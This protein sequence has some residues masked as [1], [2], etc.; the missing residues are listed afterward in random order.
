MASEVVPT[1]A[2]CVEIL[3]TPGSMFEMATIDVRGVPTRVWARA[4]PT[5]RALVQLARGHGDAIAL[6][7]EDERLSYEQTFQRVAALAE[8]LV[9]AC[10]VRKG[11]RVALAMRNYPEWPITFFAAVSAGAIVVPLNAWWTGAELQYGLADSGA[12]VLV[13]DEERARRV[14]EHLGDTDVAHLL[15]AR[16]VQRPAADGRDLAPVLATAHPERPLP[17]VEIEPDDDAT[18]FYTSGT[19]G[20]PK[21]ALGTHR[22]FTGNMVALAYGNARA[23]LRRRRP[24]DDTEPAAPAGQS[25]SLLTVPLFHATGSHSVLQGAFTTGSK[26]V[27]MYKWD[28]ERALELIE[29]ERVTAFGGVPSMV[30]QLLESPSLDTRDLS[31]LRSVSYGGAPAPP[32]LVRRIAQRFGGKPASN[33][34]GLTETSSVSTLNSGDDYLAK[35]DSV[36]APVAVTDVKVV[37]PDGDEVPVGD[38]GELWIKGPNVVRGYWRK[39]EATA[40]AFLPGGWFRSGDIARLDDEGFVYIVDRAKDMVIRGGENVYCVE[41]EAVLHEHPDVLE[42]AVVGVPHPVLGEEVA[43]VVQVRGGSPASDADL[44]AFAAERLA[45]FKVPSVWRLTTD[46]LPRNPNGKLQKRD[47]RDALLDRR[48]LEPPVP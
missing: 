12:T 14:A 37:G 1:P 42:V 19:T 39:P 44:R 13:A 20:F 27:M 10:G 35:P 45:A 34:Y 22:N 47:I 17:P 7:Y 6:V 8:H 16:S 2:E 32:D 21:G 3:C 48:A 15:V 31:S 38:V 4:V 29:R 46:E 11:D 18:I 25:A 41:V 36:G 28:P 30:I 5:M 43:A 23:S 24:K 9:D 33:G 26:L 40:E